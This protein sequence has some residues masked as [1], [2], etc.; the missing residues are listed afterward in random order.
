M[1][2]LE[3]VMQVILYYRQQWSLVDEWT[4]VDHMQTIL[5]YSQQWCL[6]DEWTGVDHAVILYYR[7]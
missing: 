4:G 1:N 5:Y 2:G 6:V 7:Q 3:W